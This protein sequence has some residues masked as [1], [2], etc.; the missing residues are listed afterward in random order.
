ME[1]DILENTRDLF[2]RIATEFDPE[3]THRLRRQLQRLMTRHAMDIRNAIASHL[4]DMELEITKL[5]ET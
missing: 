1:K 2:E 3:G 4:S 5:D